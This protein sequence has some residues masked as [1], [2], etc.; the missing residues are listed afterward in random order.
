[1]AKFTELFAA[2]ENRGKHMLVESLHLETVKSYRPR[3]FHVVLD[4]KCTPLSIL[5]STG[6]IADSGDTTATAD[7]EKF[8]SCE[9]VSIS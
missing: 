9:N 4:L 3:V 5:T 8:I 7:F 1:M 2:A 6:N